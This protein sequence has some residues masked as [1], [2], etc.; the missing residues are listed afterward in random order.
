MLRLGV[1]MRHN[2]SRSALVV[3]EYILAISHCV[4]DKLIL[5][6]QFVSARRVKNTNT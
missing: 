1:I 4:V 6:V 2:G 3:L 5:E